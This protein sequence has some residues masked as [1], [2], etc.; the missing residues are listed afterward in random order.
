MYNLVW[1]LYFDYD[2]AL[3]VEVNFITGEIEEYKSYWETGIV[4]V[5]V[6]L[7]FSVLSRGISSQIYKGV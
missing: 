5:D 3:F 6:S 4:I 1:T 7:F 2:N